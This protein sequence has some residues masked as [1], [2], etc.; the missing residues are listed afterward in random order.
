MVWEGHTN[1]VACVLQLNDARVVSGAF[2][3]TLR[4]WEVGH[5][6]CQIFLT[7]HQHYVH[8]AVQLL[9]RRHGSITHAW[10]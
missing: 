8:C 10:S 7:G 9:L 3:G 6:D 2:D 5:K 4:V 1:D